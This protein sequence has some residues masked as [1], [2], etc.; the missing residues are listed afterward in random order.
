MPFYTNKKDIVLPRQ[1]RDK[2][3]DSTQ[4]RDAFL[5]VLMVFA[6]WQLDNNANFSGRVPVRQLVAFARL[7]DIAA[8]ETRA[9]SATIPA[10]HY[11]LVD[12]HGAETAF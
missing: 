4:N 3:R 1:A 12:A 9:W 10:K 6:S 7:R 8:N 11:A 5:Q 2:H